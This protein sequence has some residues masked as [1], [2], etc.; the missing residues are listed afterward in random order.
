MVEQ[1]NASRTCPITFGHRNIGLDY[2]LNCFSLAII[3]STYNPT[4]HLCAYFQLVFLLNFCL[5]PG[6]RASG[7][8]LRMPSSSLLIN[9]PFNGSSLLMVPL[10]LFLSNAFLDPIF[11]MHILDPIFLFCSL[12]QWKSNRLLQLNNNKRSCDIF[13]NTLLQ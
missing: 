5:L 3:S 12:A 10:S 11:Q 8:I 2:I 13:S 6:I 9:C 4:H 1:N 7:I